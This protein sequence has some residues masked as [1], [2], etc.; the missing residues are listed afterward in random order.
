MSHLHLYIQSCY[1]FFLSLA[2]SSLI[3]C[4]AQGWHSSTAIKKVICRSASLNLSALRTAMHLLYSYFLQI[5]SFMR[6]MCNVCLYYFCMFFNFVLDFHQVSLLLNLRCFS[7]Q[8]QEHGFF[9]IAFKKKR[10]GKLVTGKT[11]KILILTVTLEGEEQWCRYLCQK[12]YMWAW[13][14]WSRGDVLRNQG[15]S[16]VISCQGSSDDSNAGFWFKGITV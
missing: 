12:R 16:Y 5:K 2:S 14:S 10:K 3:I 11:R 1:F 15:Q 9:L 6:W 4:A 7:L 8:H 13:Q